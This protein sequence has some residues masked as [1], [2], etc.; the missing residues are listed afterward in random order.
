V[1]KFPPDAEIGPVMELI[2][3]HLSAVD[4]DEPPMRDAED[5]PVKVTCREPGAL[6][7]LTGRGTNDEDDETSR[8]PA[9]KNPLLTQHG[10]ESLELLI[11]DYI[12]FVE[13]TEDGERLVAPTTKFVIHYIAYDRSAL[14]H[15]HAI[16]TLPVVL[17]NDTMLTDTGL[18]RKYSIVFRLEPK[19][20]SFVPTEED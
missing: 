9:P 11:G 12:V 5:L 13:A 14:P 1:P 15:V 17:P 8:L 7:E 20:L 2:D 19:L 4:A 18:N 3:G 10:K 16:Q 6:H